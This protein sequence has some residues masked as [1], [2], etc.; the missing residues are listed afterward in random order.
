MYTTV[1]ILGFAREPGWLPWAVTYFFLIGLSAASCFLSLPGL[2]GQL[3]AWQGVSR[4]ALLVALVTGV[5]GPIALLADLHQPGRFLNFYLHPNLGSWMAWGAFFIPI[6]VFGLFMYAWLCLRPRLARLGL[7]GGALAR[8]YR[9]LAYGGHDNR[10]AIK[11]AAVVAGTGA[12]LVLLYT[13][14]E[15]MVVQARAVWHTSLLPVLLAATAVSGGLGAVGLVS[16]MNGQ[17][18]GARLLKQGLVV[19]QTVALLCVLGWFLAGVTGLSAACADALAAMGADASGWVVGGWVLASTL[20]AMWAAHVKGGGLMLPCALALHLAWLMRW[21]ILISGQSLPKMGATTYR[22][23]L[24]LTP[25]GLLGVVGMLGLCVA[26][27]IVLTSL[28]PWNEQAD[29]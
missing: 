27:Y 25:D 10:G 24:T 26:I 14:M 8:A 22:Y 6:Y 18:G 28:V 15:V 4:H 17:Q 29:A 23:D 5:A 12:A 9:V 13:G 11:A 7:Q 1:E 19:S 3:P 16:V 2:V 20:A 21:L